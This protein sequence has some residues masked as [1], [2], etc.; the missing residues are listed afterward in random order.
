MNSSQLKSPV[1]GDKRIFFHYI[2]MQALLG[3]VRS[4]VLQC[5]QLITKTCLSCVFK[6]KTLTERIR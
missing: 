6:R 2:N 1:Q 5:G 3:I 4:I